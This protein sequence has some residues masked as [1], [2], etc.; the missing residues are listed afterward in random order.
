MS[1]STVTARHLAAAAVAA[2]AV[3]G[4]VVPPAS[5]DDHG[6]RSY[7]PRVE[8]SDV[9]FDAHGPGDHFG[10]SPNREWVEITNTGRRSA[11]LDGWTL[12][13]ED[14]RTYTFHHY[15]L[16]GRA[17]VRVH[18]GFGRDN[19]TDLYQDRRHA[20]WA[21]RSGIAVLRNDRGRYIDAVTWNGERHREGGHHLHH[22]VR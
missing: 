4:A 13:D 10:R 22:Q 7:E 15:R 16:R 20:L 14:G 1:V 12:S 3:A 9:Q 11:N 2:V 21:G 8:I 18:T 5:A 6:P 19:R 17:A